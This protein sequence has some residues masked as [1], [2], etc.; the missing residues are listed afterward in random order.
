LDISL[1]MLGS[2]KEKKLDSRKPVELLNSRND[3]KFDIAKTIDIM[4]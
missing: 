3:K 4:I 1:A 2:W